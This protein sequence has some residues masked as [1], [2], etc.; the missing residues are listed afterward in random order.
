[1]W[2][3]DT[4][5]RKTRGRLSRAAGKNVETKSDRRRLVRNARR[6][7]RNTRNLGLMAPGTAKVL[8]AGVQRRT[9]RTVGYNTIHKR[10]TSAA[11]TCTPVVVPAARCRRAS[12]SLTAGG[13]NNIVPQITALAAGMTDNE[14][15]QRSTDSKAIP[16][17]PPP[18]TP[19]ECAS[20]AS[21]AAFLVGARRPRTTPPPIP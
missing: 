1:M 11:V 8:R 21:A 19:F 15:V 20:T 16:P 7:D 9:V 4:A 12:L 18:P 3:L 13:D 2:S 6:E 14:R 10:W 17:P 5:G